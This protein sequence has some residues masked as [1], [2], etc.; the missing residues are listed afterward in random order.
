MQKYTQTHSNFDLNSLRYIENSLDEIVIAL[1]LDEYGKLADLVKICEKSGVHT[2]F[3][4]D[5]NEIIP[6]RPYTED[7]MG[8]PVI[9]IRYV[10]L[11]NTFNA[12]VKRAF[13]ILCS[14]VGLIILSPLLLVICIIIKATSKGPLIFKQERVGFRNETFMM[15]KFRSMKVQDEAEEKKA[16]TVKDDPRV[17]KFGK[18]I[19]KT[20]LDELPQLVNILKGDMSIVGPRPE[21]PFFVEKFKEEIPRYMIKHQVRPGLTGWAQVNGLRGD[22][23]I[24]KRIE[25][26]LYYIEN[27]TFWFDIKIM[28]LTIFKGFVNKNAY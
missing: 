11:S 14:S 16:W 21:R 20:S 19:R 9:N 5:Y 28:F 3:V 24:K 2:Q 6:S 13:D 22:T 27:W 7:I 18:F 8:L 17:T 23:S 12:I 10:P 1:N 15:Y 25:Y 26:D 4:P